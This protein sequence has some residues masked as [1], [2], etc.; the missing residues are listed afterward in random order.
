VLWETMDLTRI[1]AVGPEALGE[2]RQY[3]PA[4]YFAFNMRNDT[5]S[6]DFLQANA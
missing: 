3:L 6:T 2:L 5:I 4:L 1:R